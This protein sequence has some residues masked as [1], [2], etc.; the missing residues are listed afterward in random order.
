MNEWQIE[1]DEPRFFTDEATGLACAMLRGPLGHWCGYVGVPTDHALYGKHYDDFP[2]RAHG[3]LTWSGKLPGKYE[4]HSQ[5]LWWFGFDCAHSEDY[6]P[7]LDFARFGDEVYRNEAYVRASLAE[8]CEDVI[9]LGK[10]LA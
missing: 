5:S 7:K 9:I 2:A 6:A 4:T 1:G 3:G 8:L 10:E